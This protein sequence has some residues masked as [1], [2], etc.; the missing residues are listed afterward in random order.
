MRTGLLI[1]TTWVTLCLSLS[2][3]GGCKMYKRSAANLPGWPDGAT[4][5][6]PPNRM[7]TG[8][9]PIGQGSMTEAGGGGGVVVGPATDSRMVPD[10]PV[11][12]ASGTGGSGGGL[13]SGGVG[14]SGGAAA[15]GGRRDAAGCT[16][17]NLVRQDCPMLSQA[18]YPNGM[19]G[20][21]CDFAGTS[22]AGAAC[23]SSGECDK[24]AFCTGVMGG[25][26]SL[27]RDF[28]DPAIAMC[29]GGRCQPLSGYPGT[30]YCIP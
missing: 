25:D 11:A 13:D 21:C 2:L 3:V 26:A 16:P 17:C 15:D 22:G 19:G 27:C 29:P 24:G 8:D 7:V 6:V 1:A 4:F 9:G 20:G 23:F 30:G 28:C 5:E 12:D 14:G 18:C 10:L